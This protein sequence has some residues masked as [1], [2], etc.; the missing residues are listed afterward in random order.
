[1]TW[2]AG[3][4]RQ[5]VTVWEDG[6]HLF[7]WGIPTNV[8]KGAAT[9]MFA[10]AFV[11]DDGATP[12]ALVI[13]DI[14]VITL[15]LR[16]RVL[17]FLRADHPTCPIADEHILLT[18]THT[19]SGPSGYS[20]YLFYAFSGPGISQKIVD[21]YARGAAN[22]I[23]FAW[24]ER[25]DAEVL[26]GSEELPLNVPV[27][28]NRSLRPH[29]RNEEL[30]GRPAPSSEEAT[31]RRMTLLELRR[32]T[33]GSPIGILTWFPTHA[34]SIHSDNTKVHGDNRGLAAL[35]FE[36]QLRAEYGREIVTAF[37]QEAAGDTTPNF[38]WEP[39]RKLIIGAFDSDEDSAQFVAN[40]LRRLA[41]RIRAN[42]AAMRALPAENSG[43]LRY[44]NLAQLQ[45][46]TPNYPEGVVQLGDAVLGMG[47]MQ[48]TK[49]G[50]GPIH[51]LRHAARRATTWLRGTRPGKG[52]ELRH[53]HGNKLPFLDTGQGRKG[54]AFG[55]ISLNN[56]QVP[57][58]L[59]Q[60]VKAY[61][62]YLSK[63]AVDE[64]PW[65]P[66]VLPFQVLKIGP[67]WL[68]AIPGEPTTMVGQRLREA[69]QQV[70]QNAGLSDAHVVI[71]GYSN[72]YAAYVTTYEEYF[73]Q[74][75]EGASTMFGPHTFTA[76]H[77]IT[78]ELSDFLARGTSLSVPVAE[79]PKFDQ[80]V[81]LKR[82][83]EAKH[84]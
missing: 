41:T 17:E 74:W 67:V 22:A 24:A 19:H 5:E 26:L 44:I 27:A 10:R 49:E 54:K 76:M 72:D 77:W 51:A 83:F 59:D 4:S 53:N 28:F 6:I 66:T 20:E 11:L 38:R 31:Y 47:F 30:Q 60:T 81:M 40:A 33:D 37:A 14:G 12:L 7:G 21:T 42:D 13:L 64:L 58:A 1:M 39:K 75:Y 34:T 57:G 8:A 45:V 43:A 68:A 16:R 65:T 84:P 23:A 18:A 50:P 3:A 61:K 82:E 48:G 71:A 69:V 78:T 80:T 9:P 55:L 32:T 56:P 25:E 52:R 2:K 29:L 62:H 36:K 46:P 63:G 15:T 70:A 79:P 35:D 73:E